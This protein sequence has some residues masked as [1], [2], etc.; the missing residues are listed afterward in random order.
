MLHDS[1][2]SISLPLSGER[3]CIAAYE[4][5]GRT[6]LAE[7]NVSEFAF[8]IYVERDGLLHS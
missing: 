6:A 7:L 1:V 2:A 8:I 4:M 3:L 5:H